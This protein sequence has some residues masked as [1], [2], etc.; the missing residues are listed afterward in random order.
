MTVKIYRGSCHCAKFVYEV[1]LPEIKS[2]DECNC[3]ICFKKGYAWVFPK[4]D[5]HLRFVKGAKEDLTVYSFGKSDFSHLFCSHCGTPVMGTNPTADPS[6]Y[7][8]ART[9]QDLDIWSLKA[10][11]F[12]GKSLPPSYK[13]PAYY[14]PEPEAGD[15]YDSTYYGSCHCGAVQTAVKTKS[16]DTYNLSKETHKILECNCN[17]CVRG[18]QIW[19]YLDKDQAAIH[20]AEHMTYYMFNLQVLRKG[21]CKH[22]GVNVVNEVAPKTD[23]QIEALTGTPKMMYDLLHT[24]RNINL[25]MLDDFDCSKLELCRANGREE[26]PGDWVNP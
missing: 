7:L 11:T 6:L 2:Y 22:C 20:G 1:N 24:K 9:I 4:D 23:N 14:G 26:I 12:D 5:S 21:F 19:G 18:G 8:N 16:L 3:S 17:Y 25:R 15:K 10:H 13:A